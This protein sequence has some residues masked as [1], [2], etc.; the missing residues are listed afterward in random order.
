[1]RSAEFQVS[2]VYGFGESV[3]KMRESYSF[4]SAL[5]VLWVLPWLL[6]VTISLWVAL[7]FFSDD[8]DRSLDAEAVKSV[9]HPLG[10]VLGEWK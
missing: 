7:R 9:T 1:M 10:Q 8:E 6:E 3:C 4:A 2:S 5:E